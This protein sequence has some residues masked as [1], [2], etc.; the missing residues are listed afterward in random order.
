MATSAPV[1]LGIGGIAAVF[2]ISGIQGKSVSSIFQGDFGKPPNPQGPGG[3]GLSIQGKGTEQPTENNLPS[4][5]ISP[6]TKRDPVTWGRSDQGI[7]GITTPGAPL[8]AMGNGQIEIAHDP[9]GFGAN[10]PVLHI[11]NDGAFYYGHSV[12]L[13][14]SGAEVKKG[15]IIARAN[16]NG[17]GNATTPGS[18]EIGRWPP[19]SFTSA[20]AAIRAWFIGLPR[21]A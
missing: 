19:G 15:Q 17:Q 1:A 9:S 6:F 12:P 16:T 11:E 14:P 5:L 7:D 18:F 10:Y 4:G 8:V 2:L 20:G 3:E 21:I 13:V